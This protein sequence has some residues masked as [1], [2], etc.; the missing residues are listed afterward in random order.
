VTGH[1]TGNVS[2]CVH[3]CVDDAEIGRSGC[4]VQD[5]GRMVVQDVGFRMKGGRCRDGS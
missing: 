5:D 1:V 4:R 2:V 3:Q